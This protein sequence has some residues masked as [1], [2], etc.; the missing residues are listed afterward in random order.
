MKWAI[1]I[2]PTTL[3]L[4]IGCIEAIDI[5]LSNDS[6][7]V[8][9]G[10][11]TNETKAHKVKL[12]TSSA[13]DENPVF[14]K[15]DPIL[16][17]ALVEI[18]ENE[19]IAIQLI[20][21]RN[22]NYFTPRDFAG[23]IGSTYNLSV[24]LKDGSVYYS[25]PE[26]LQPI[27]G[28]MNSACFEN[29]FKEVST[30]ESKT[31]KPQVSFSVEISDNSESIDYYRWGYTG[32]YEV[33]APLASTLPESEDCEPELPPHPDFPCPIKRCWATDH[34]VEFLNVSSDQLYNGKTVDQTI[35]STPA[36]RQ[37]N[38]AYAS[39]IE[40][41]SLTKSA[42]DYWHA[43][44]GQIDNNGTIFETPNYQIKGNILS[45]NHPDQLVL[46]YFGASAKDSVRVIVY[47][48]DVPGDYGPIPCDQDP[49]PACFDCRLWPATK[50][51][52][53]YWPN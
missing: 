4:L 36:N 47:A 1:S 29:T 6:V 44:S 48:G 42:F 52:P 20:E 24:T 27:G 45:L 33:E 28:K 16:L 23:T 17:G 9:E 50:I 22:A 3:I 13:F 38:I 37:F 7:L 15:T 8:I 11:I 30:S 2:L 51:K 40:Q 41:Y 21:G 31:K 10:L 25:R 43:I 46:G 12:S 34:G 5:P 26:R 19:S 14:A 18:I 32:I 39:N 53:D 35:Y 49:P